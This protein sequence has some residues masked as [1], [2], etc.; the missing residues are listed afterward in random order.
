M[1][2]LLDQGCLHTVCLAERRGIEPR[3]QRFGDAG[4]TQRSLLGKFYFTTPLSGCQLK[5]A[6]HVESPTIPST[7]ILLIL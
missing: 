1:R 6:F 7:V 5:R 3:F 2:H 4:P